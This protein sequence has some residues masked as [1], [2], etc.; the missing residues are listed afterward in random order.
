[1]P[2]QAAR[3]T[4]PC[5]YKI[6]GRV[7]L[8]RTVH[9]LRYGMGSLPFIA[10]LGSLSQRDPNLCPRRNAHGHASCVL[11]IVAVPHRWPTA[12]QFP[13]LHPDAGRARQVFPP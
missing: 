4:A 10:F 2:L 5:R 13:T 9:S 6:R 8:L 3:G 12:R 7:E 11:S 1:M